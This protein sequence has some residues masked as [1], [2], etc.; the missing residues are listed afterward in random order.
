[1]LAERGHV[2]GKAWCSVWENPCL[3][4]G[5]AG[6]PIPYTTPTPIPDTQLLPF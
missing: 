5:T 3:C 1:M 2:V 4:P 6:P